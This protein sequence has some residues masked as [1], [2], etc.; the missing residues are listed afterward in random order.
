MNKI[1]VS[2]VYHCAITAGMRL[3]QTRE[4]EPELTIGL[5]KGARVVIDHHSYKI[6]RVR[7]KTIVTHPYDSSTRAPQR[8]EI[9]VDLKKL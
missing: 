8:V 3:V 1:T 2:Y 5:V 6:T 4:V 9:T 7:Y